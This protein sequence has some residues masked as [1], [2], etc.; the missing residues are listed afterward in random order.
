MDVESPEHLQPAYQR[1]LS[2]LS[3]DRGA[4]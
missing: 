3:S 1:A 4:A 2:R